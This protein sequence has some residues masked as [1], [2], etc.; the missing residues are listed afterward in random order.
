MK[1]K[2]T[3]SFNKKNIIPYS[4]ISFLLW[5]KHTLFYYMHEFLK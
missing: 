3:Y 5:K 1:K 2:K 4:F